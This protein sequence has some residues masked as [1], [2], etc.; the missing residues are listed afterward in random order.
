M[1]QGHNLE[2]GIAVEH[3]KSLTCINWDCYILKAENGK[4]NAHASENY[5]KVCN[6][7]DMQDVQ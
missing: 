7:F 2:N 3:E 4:V 6:S 1:Y 5:A